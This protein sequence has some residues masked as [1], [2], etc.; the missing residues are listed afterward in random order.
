MTLGERIKLRR[1]EQ[2]LSLRDLAEQADLTASFLS[3][4]ERDQASPSIESLRKIS[5]ALDVPLFYFLM[6]QDETSP[7]VRRN[8]RRRLTKPADG[9]VFELLA[10]DI[11]RRMEAV[12]TT[13]EV[14]DGRIPLTLRQETEEF[15]F[16]LSGT[17]EVQ[18]GSESYL[19]EAGDSIY[20]LGALLRSIQAQGERSVQYLSVI[21]PPII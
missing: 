5:K 21:T 8:E 6:E 10:P 2:E 13:V 9:M 18:L 1:L 3:Q 14:K 17:L 12:L 16:I 4:I 11:N 20:F 15:I 7:V 19:L